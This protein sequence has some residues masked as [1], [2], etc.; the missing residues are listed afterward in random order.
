VNG[1]ASVTVGPE[2]PFVAENNTE[3]NNQGV[4]LVALTC[5]ARLSRSPA[6]GS[7]TGVFFVG[8]GALYEYWKEA[9]L[10]G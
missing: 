7:R 8:L 10:V 9:F 4:G 3:L 1:A 2:L 6:L 5:A